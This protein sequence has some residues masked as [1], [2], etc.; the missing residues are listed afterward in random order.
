MWPVWSWDSKIDL[1]SRMNWWNELIFLH[2]STNVGN[3]KSICSI[4]KIYTICCVLAQILYWEKSCS[5][6]VGQN[7]LNQSDCKIFKSTISPEQIDEIV[8]CWYKFTKVKN[9]SKTFWLNI[10]K[11]WCGQSG[12]WILKLTVSQE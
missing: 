8:S 6:D 10:I 12:L 3:T 4:I 11:N 1:I 5:R 2:A 9:S 7:A